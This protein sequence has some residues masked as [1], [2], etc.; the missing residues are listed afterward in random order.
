MAQLLNK[1]EI[2]ANLITEIF[3]NDVSKY[4]AERISDDEYFSTDSIFRFVGEFSS[5]QEI[6]RWYI[7][8]DPDFH[9]LPDKVMRIILMDEQRIINQ[10]FDDYLI[11]D[12]E[13]K[14]ILGSNCRQTIYY[15]F[16]KV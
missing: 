3:N 5:Q 1:S 13:V 14:R 4:I 15:L 11:I 16:E 12:I 6:A 9:N 2:T 8:K 10:M 7:K